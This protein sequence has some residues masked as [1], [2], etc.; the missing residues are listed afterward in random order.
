MKNLLVVGC[1]Y[2]ALYYHPDPRWSY[3]WLLKE[4]L[5]ADNLINLSFG[6]NSPSGCTRTLEWYLRNPVKGKPNWIYIQVPN[7]IREE[8]YLSGTN[9]DYIQ[10]LTF[11]CTN[12]EKYILKDETIELDNDITHMPNIR[13]ELA[14]S[15]YEKFRRPEDKNYA[16][17][18]ELIKDVPWNQILA[19]G[20]T[21]FYEKEDFSDTWVEE[22][23][24]KEDENTF[25]L[26]SDSVVNVNASWN[27]SRK[28][29]NKR[30]VKVI[31]DFH[32]LWFS[33]KKNQIVCINTIRREI[34]IMQM[35][36]KRWNIPIFFNCTDSMYRQKGKGVFQTYDDAV[37]H[38]DSIIDWDYV[39]KY[40][41][42]NNYSKSCANIDRYYDRHPGRM[43]HEKY[44]DVI[45]PQVKSLLP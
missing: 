16:S 39:I 31:N 4:A 27:S 7:G 43:S 45:W 40:E 14:W 24:A 38:Y 30:Y 22:Y 37:T 18:E 44:F 23:V 1:S 34:S 42:I 35:L 9:W 2:S 13:H 3:T 32:K 19:V 33:H 29:K 15:D 21:M 20:G 26:T 5:G 12:D 17:N 25:F 28:L 36:A 10:E 11:V 41:S 8:Y 6:G